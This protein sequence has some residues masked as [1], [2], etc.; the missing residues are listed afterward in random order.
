MKL[1]TKTVRLVLL[2]AF[3]P[4]ICMMATAQ[5]LKPKEIIYSRLPT[6]L[7]QSPTG[8]N[9]PTI[10]AIG[11]DG[12]ND[13]QIAVGM[14]PRISDDGRFLLFRRIVAAAG[15]VI[16]YNPYAS[17]AQGNLWVRD[18]ANNSETMI[19]DFTGG[20]RRLIGYYFSPESN[21]GNYQIIL[22]YGALFY[23]F[24]L[25]G[26]NAVALDPY[27]GGGFP[28]ENDTFPVLRRGD[29]LIAANNRDRANFGLM[30]RTLGSET[31]FDVP[32]TTGNDWNPSWSNDNQFVGF[33]TIRVNGC[34]NFDSSAGCNYPYFFNK[35]NKIKPDGSN[36]ALLSDLSGINTNG[37]AFGTIWT[38]DNSKIIAAARING[39]ASLYAFTTNGSG[40][41]TRISI[42]NG[43][44]PDFV[45]GIVQTRQ[46]QS[47]IS[48]GGGLIGDSSAG[49]AEPTDDVIL[50]GQYSM[51]T[52]IG[53]PIVGD[54]SG[55]GFSLSN[56]FQAAIPLAP[57]AASVE[58]GGRV[59]SR[60]GRGLSGARIVLTD[61]TGKNRTALTGSF[62]YF[63]FDEVHAG[64]TYIVKISSK[65]F[66]FAPQIVNVT[67][68]LSNL[69]FTAQ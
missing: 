28:R 36:R 13:R 26:T 15:D 22:D 1:S 57:T 69:T 38:D 32:N 44:A 40:T 45:G 12:A 65:R 24:N 20:N 55:G 49:Y 10:W 11:Q 63:R 42:S 4:V 23:K 46:E 59:L 3:F 25:D 61:S 50:A 16:H 62:G 7:N 6:D 43:N 48:N 56:G 5:Q 31:P 9:S 39:V 18:L 68:D 30:T 67:A 66:T 64:E 58:V 53:E 17:Q 37:I 47:L 35:I 60:D 2:F 21:Q 54:V 51:N 19:F 34:L 8:A 29:S 41:Y 33:T 27:S 14:E 52:S